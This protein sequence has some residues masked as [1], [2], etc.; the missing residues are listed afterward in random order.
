M[1]TTGAAGALSADARK[2]ANARAR[3]AQDKIKTLIEERGGVDKGL[4]RRPDRERPDLGNKVR[5]SA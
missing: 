4:P 2:E 3:E 5:A 1:C